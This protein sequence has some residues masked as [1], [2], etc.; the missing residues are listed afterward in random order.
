MVYCRFPLTSILGNF[1]A[2]FIAVFLLENT[3]TTF[4]RSSFQSLVTLILGI[5]LVY[6]NAIFLFEQQKNQKH[7]KFFKKTSGFGFPDGFF[8]Y[9]PVEHITIQ[10]PKYF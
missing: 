9:M 8:F 7:A 1:W 5:S 3:K 6:R 4:P 2:P 10:I